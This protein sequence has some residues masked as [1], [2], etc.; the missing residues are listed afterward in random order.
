MK[1]VMLFLM[2]FSVNIFAA[3][4]NINKASAEEIAK[5]LKGVGHKKALAIVAYRKEIGSFKSVD[6][7]MTVKGIGQKTLKNNQQDIKLSDKK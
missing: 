4:V 1:K 3:P 7:L 2:L 6:E 5:S